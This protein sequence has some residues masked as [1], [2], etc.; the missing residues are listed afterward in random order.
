VFINADKD[1]RDAIC[2][3]HPN[4]IVEFL[5]NNRLSAKSALKKVFNLPNLVLKQ[6]D[7]SSVNGLAGK[8]LRDTAK[9]VY[10]LI[11]GKISTSTAENGGGV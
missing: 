10:T 9:R 6:A 4:R 1:K 3:G 5:A 11:S 7:L 2:L 8:P